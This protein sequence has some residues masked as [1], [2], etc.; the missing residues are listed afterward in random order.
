MARYDNEIDS[1]QFEQDLLDAYFH[2]RSNLP[3]KDKESGLDYKKQF[4]TTADIATELDEMGGVR[5]D[6]INAYLV[7]R[8]YKIA[9]QEDGT[10]AWAIWERVI[11]PG[12]LIS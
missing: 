10:V 6:T 11:P 4:K 3:K 9:T 7:A 1:D 2:F 8:D 5:M 12:R